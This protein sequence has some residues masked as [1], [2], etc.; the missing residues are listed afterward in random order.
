[1]IGG[2]KE[3]PMGLVGN[4]SIW[5]STDAAENNRVIVYDSSSYIYQDILSTEDQLK[6]ITTELL[7]LYE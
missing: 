4:N 5:I 1:M 2:W 3:D 7:K 6:N